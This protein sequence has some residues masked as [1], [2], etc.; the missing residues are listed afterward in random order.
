MPFTNAQLFK[1]KKCTN[2]DQTI[3]D[4]RIRQAGYHVCTDLDAKNAK[5]R[6]AVV[7]MQGSMSK[8]RWASMSIDDKRRF[9]H[10]ED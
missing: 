7:Q 6:F 1:C 8:D 10:I 5:Y 3:K 2:L 9:L 4:Q